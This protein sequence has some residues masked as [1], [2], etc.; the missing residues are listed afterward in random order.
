MFTS[1]DVVFQETVFPFAALVPSLNQQRD[2]TPVLSSIDSPIGNVLHK[3][4][5]SLEDLQTWRLEYLPPNKKAL[6]FKWAFTIKYRS[7]G[8]IERY[9]TRLVVLGNHQE[10][11]LDYEETFAPVAKM[12][13]VRLFLD[14]AAKM[15]HEVHQMDVHNVFLHGDL[16][17]EVYMKLPPGFCPDGETRVCRKSLY[18]LK[19][20]PRCWFAKLT[21]AW[22]AYGFTQTRSDYSLFVYINNGVSLRILLYVDDLI[23]SEN[24]PTAIQTFKITCLSV[25]T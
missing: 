8:T 17:E 4:Y 19:Q 10:E 22:K 6:G 21:D 15:N 20:T 24:S 9:K 7:D 13:M 11:G 1:R 18:G 25:S 12:K 23:I 14:L 16:H 5:D 2:V 3:E